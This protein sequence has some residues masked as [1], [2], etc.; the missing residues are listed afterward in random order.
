MWLSSVHIFVLSK[1]WVFWLT[2]LYQLEHFDSDFIFLYLPLSALHSVVCSFIS[3]LC[4]YIS[5]SWILSRNETGNITRKVLLT[6]ENL[7]CSYN[8][9]WYCPVARYAKIFITNS[10]I[11]CDCIVYEF[12]SNCSTFFI[13]WCFFFFRSKPLHIPIWTKGLL[14][15]WFK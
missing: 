2:T 3:V 13:I 4:V 14:I 10:Q 12:R 7:K 1:I 11:C 9:M 5:R 8:R 6:I 15:L